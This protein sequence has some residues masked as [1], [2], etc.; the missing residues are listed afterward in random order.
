[1]LAFACNLYTC[2]TMEGASEESAIWCLLQ[3]CTFFFEFRVL[4]VLEVRRDECKKKMTIE[5]FVR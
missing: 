2:Q 5:L 3:C 4:F 1:M